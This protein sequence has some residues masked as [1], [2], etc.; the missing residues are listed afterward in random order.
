MAGSHQFTSS[1]VTPVLRKSV[2]S[3]LLAFLW[4]RN[5]SRPT[6]LTMQF[7]TLSTYTRVSVTQGLRNYWFQNVHMNLKVFFSIC[8]SFSRD[9]YGL[10]ACYYEV[11]FK[12]HSLPMAMKFWLRKHLQTRS[13]LYY[14]DSIKMP[15]QQLLGK[16]SCFPDLLWTSSC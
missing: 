15:H 16:N 2:S 7:K 9:I 13:W 5:Q 11:L 14:L 1:P 8:P 4:H 6:N 12:V 3:L 10:L